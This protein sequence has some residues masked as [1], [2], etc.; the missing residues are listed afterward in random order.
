MPAIRLQVRRRRFE[1][2]LKDVIRNADAQ[3]DPTDR[4]Q[5]TGPVLPRGRGHVSDVLWVLVLGRAVWVDVCGHEDV[6]GG[7]G[8]E[9]PVHAEED[10]AEGC[11]EHCFPDAVEVAL[12]ERAH[13][14]ELV[15]DGFR[16][17]IGVVEVTT[18][19]VEFFGGEVE[20]D[21]VGGVVGEGEIVAAFVVQAEDLKGGAGEG[22]VAGG[23]GREGRFEVGVVAVG[24][25]GAFCEPEGILDRSVV[26]ADAG[27]GTPELETVLFLPGEDSGVGDGG[28]E[29]GE[30]ADEVCVGCFFGCSCGLLGPGDGTEDL[31][32]YSGRRA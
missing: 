1:V 10:A 2:A 19:A 13:V 24:V 8:V 30:E 29:E 3:R 16:W 25:G 31:V 23:V 32:E 4:E 7:E 15:G 11:V 21:V 28:V 5:L 14:A 20:G 17:D 9:A 22:G 18:D 6:F 26:E 27:Q 12:D